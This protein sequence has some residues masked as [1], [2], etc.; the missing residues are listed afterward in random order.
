MKL[1]DLCV[2]DVATCTPNHTI[3]VAAQLMREHHTGDLVVID[4]GD[5]EQEPVGMI[6]DR[7]IVIEVVALGRDPAKTL[8]GDVMSS[9][10]VVASESE[11]VEDAL[12][13]MAAHGVR[14]IPILNDSRCV[15]GIFAFDDLLRV[16]AQQATRL[17]DVITK[18]QTK[19]QRLRR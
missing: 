8:V 19:E 9:R 1:K 18:E 4:D 14:R 15:A 3:S 6:T 7:D 16:H 10:T 5:E 17:L 13:R 11:D 12:E 2:L